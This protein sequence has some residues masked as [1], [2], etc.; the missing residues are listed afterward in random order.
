MSG[1]SRSSSIS[2][3]QELPSSPS[4]SLGDE[5]YDEQRIEIPKWVHNWTDE[6]RAELAIQLLKSVSPS[7][8]T[9]S[10][11]RLTPLFE[12]RDF[13]VLLPNEL[14]FHL[15]SFLDEKSLA[16][17]A[18][19]SKAWNKFASDSTVWRELYMRRGWKVNQDM[20]DWYLRWAEQ[21]DQWPLG[22]KGMHPRI[23][24]EPEPTVNNGK[25]K[26]LDHDITSMVN[27][28]TDE[29]EMAQKLYELD[30]IYPLL[31]YD[32]E[33][34]PDQGQSH[35]RHQSEQ[36]SPYIHIEDVEMAQSPE[37][38]FSN[39][40][41]PISFAASTPLDLSPAHDITMSDSRPRNSPSV[42]P[43]GTMR[44]PLAGQR[45]GRF[46]LSTTGFMPSLH[47]PRLPMYSLGSSLMTPPSMLRKISHRGNP[48][49]PLRIPGLN[50]GTSNSTVS[51]RQ[52]RFFSHQRASSLDQAQTQALSSSQP[53]S[54][55]SPTSAAAQLNNPNSP[56][57]SKSLWSVIRH[58]V[59]GV[60]GSAGWPS[61]HP[62]RQHESNEHAGSSSNHN[63]HSLISPSLPAW[64]M[65]IPSPL[66]STSRLHRNSAPSTA[67]SSSSSSAA[68]AA[69][70]TNTH[71]NAQAASNQGDVNLP[72]IPR[73]ID[74]AGPNTPNPS[75]I[76][77]VDAL[78]IHRDPVTKR[79]TINWRFLCQQRK[80]L[81]QNWNS[82]M[83]F[84][85]ELPGHTEGIYCIQFDDDKIVSGSRD[86]T[87]KIWDLTSEV[88]LRT[89]VGHT[90]SVLCLQYDDTRIVS[91][92]SDTTII[93]WDLETGKILQRL[94]GHAD[95][96]LSLRFEKDT[97]V[98]CSKDRTVKIWNIET[99][100]MLRTLVGHRAA[101]NAVQFSP[102]SAP[103]SPFPDS[104]KVVVSASGDKTI[105]IWSFETGECLKTLEG[106]TRGIACIQFEGN[107]IVSGSSDRSIKI[108]DIAKGECVRTLVGHEGLVRTL[109]FTGGRIISGGYDETL[110]IWDQESGRLLADMEG[111]HT[112]RVFKLQFNDSKIVSC[113]QDQKIIIWNFAV[114]V[115]TT[116]L[117]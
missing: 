105:K 100:E 91:G 59:M 26:M 89:Y 101:V 43:S 81:E 92:S 116:F 48:P 106:H 75:D 12:Y 65:H 56:L 34:Y 39:D 19:V 73:R 5:G 94:S 52:S 32:E 68:A 20:I 36:I 13:L 40:S 44:T 50:G 61:L 55:T 85:K 17:V 2:Q 62:H 15:L 37:D 7:V 23:H 57:S 18:L 1:P 99:G 9:R 107:V 109:Q 33:N 82:G 35:Q 10:Y 102:D 51:P 90:A 69:T 87:I 112:H 21:E 45:L 96:V 31:N 29:Y 16:S 66:T 110:K 49:A 63:H 58:G 28:Q 77:S 76:L 103:P 83:H 30:A 54:P 64:L 38:D 71:S 4:P 86:N 108:W 41:S 27:Q 74:F 97:V 11:A 117:M 22:P 42:S 60:S 24:F 46:S 80:I 93:V 98:S 6:Q 78:H 14:T 115:D 53:D 67:Q 95:S 47:R 114:G 3:F 70:A 84:P 104:P 72:K 79:P 25:R 88:C 8:F 113:S 111:R